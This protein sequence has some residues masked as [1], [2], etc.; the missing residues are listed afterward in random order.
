MLGKFQGGRF[1]YKIRNEF[2][3]PFRFLI[4][5][6]GHMDMLLFVSRI[7]L[8]RMPGWLSSWVPAFRDPGSSPTLGSL[9]GACFS[10][11]LC[12]CISLCFS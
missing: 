10:L 3:M 4:V 5:N 8:L 6:S 11:C 9:Q 2:D 1:G 12:P 7:P